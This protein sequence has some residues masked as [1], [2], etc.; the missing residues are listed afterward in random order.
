MTALRGIGAAV[1]LAGRLKLA[2]SI[3]ESFAMRSALAAFLL[4]ISI[5]PVL[6][7][8][9]AEIAAVVEKAVSPLIAEAQREHKECINGNVSFCIC[10]NTYTQAI[11]VHADLGYLK[12]YVKPGE[13]T[14]TGIDN[15]IQNIDGLKYW[16]NYCGRNLPNSPELDAVLIH[17]HAL[18]HAENERSIEEGRL[19]RQQLEDD[20]KTCASA[21]KIGLSVDAVPDAC[22]AYPVNKI[23]TASGHREQW[24]YWGGYLYFDDGRLTE[25]QETP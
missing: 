25:I 13:S 11:E 9:P 12:D 14:Y 24:K 16:F 15:L 20:R 22:H 1:N 7:E 10:S 2:A 3:G 5:S 21:L 4:L 19:H 18:M 8:T 6:A 17:L 23:T